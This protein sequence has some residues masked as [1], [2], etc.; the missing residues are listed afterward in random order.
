[1]AS[2]DFIA[3]PHGGLADRSDVKW[4]AGA[5][6]IGAITFNAILCFI[7]TRGIP[8]TN[9][10]VMGS[11]VVI[12]AA[13]L[14]VL[15]NNIDLMHLTL[16]TLMVFY[17]AAFSILRHVHT[18]ANALD[19]KICRDFL[20]PIVFFLLGKAVDDVK[21]ADKIV[22][23]AIVLIF[24]FAVFE[25]FFLYTFLTV[26]GIAQYYVAR[27]TLE[28]SG[29]ALDVSQGL[30]VSGFRPADQGRAL[31][32]FLGEHRVSSL[33]L[34]PSSLGNFGAL[35]AVW[36]FVRS[37]MERKLYFW[38]A[39]GGLALVVLSDTRFDA[40]FLVLAMLI[41]ITPPKITTPCVFLTPFIAILALYL[42]AAS[43]APANGVPMVEGVGL[44]DRLLYSGR[45]LLDFDI[46]NWFGVEASRAQTFDSGYGYLIANVGILGLT[47]FWVLFMS[48]RGSNR[49]FYSFRNIAAAYFAVLL[50]ISA[51]QFTIKIAAL[52]WFLVGALSTASDRDQIQFKPR[53]ESLRQPT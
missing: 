15:R 46:Y 26:F 40:Y 7:N 27:G 39:I 10:H 13:T 41:L 4:A 1:M 37:R 12:I 49:Y 36:A 9:I 16:I 44:Q 6:I 45:V 29:W 24:T 33:F 19:L 35:V 47:V 2:A 20:I 22:F 48:L 52:L 11:E 8:I 51:S 34:E 18:P 14:L 17:T 43:V 50:C 28:A 30:M 3:Q 31:L 25:Y 5:L 23:A 42:F 32:P 38:S 53:G 21:A